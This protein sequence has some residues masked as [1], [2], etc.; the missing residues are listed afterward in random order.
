MLKHYGIEA[1]IDVRRFPNSRRNPQFNL[2][3]LGLSL[4][5]I[6]IAYIWIEDLGGYRKCGYA[7]YMKTREFDEGIR[8]VTDIAGERKTAIMCAELLWF[9]CHRRYIAAFLKSQGWRVIHIYD[10]RRA[11]EHNLK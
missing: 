2:N 3:A 7:E 1:V 9:K 4:P 10:E 11:E 8:M 5:Q 6:D